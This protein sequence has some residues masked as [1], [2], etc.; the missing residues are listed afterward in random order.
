MNFEDIN[1]SEYE[2]KTPY[3][4]IEITMKEP[5]T[6]KKVICAYAGTKGEI[7]A[8]TQYVYQ[9]FIMHPINKN[10]HKIL[11]RI[12]IKEMQHMEILSDILI[13]LGVNP[14]FCTY[15]DNNI[16][17]CNNWS[18]CNLKYITSPVEFLKY[19]I[20]L[21]ESAI[22]EYNSIIETSEDEN[23]NLVISRIIEDEESHL[24]LFKAML[25]ILCNEKSTDI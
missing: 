5:I 2:V 9:S 23:L 20:C 19:N 14:K 22:K 17:L 24:K 8:S 25:N 13:Q 15:I 12:A 4:K 10:F 3:P 11:E 6:I 7:T 18:T 1:Y 21:E 16:N